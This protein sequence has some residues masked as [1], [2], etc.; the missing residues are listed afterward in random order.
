LNYRP[1]SVQV[2][3]DLADI[4]QV[5]LFRARDGEA[6]PCC[7]AVRSAGAADP[8]PENMHEPLDP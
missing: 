8:V 5:R 4:L 3:V 7:D 6:L 1:A 2:F